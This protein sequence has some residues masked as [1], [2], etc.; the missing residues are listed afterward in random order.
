MLLSGS[1]LH[2]VAMYQGWIKSTAEEHYNMSYIEIDV[3]TGLNSGQ[4]HPPGTYDRLDPTQQLHPP[5]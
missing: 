4:L 2:V 5:A 3:S 1:I